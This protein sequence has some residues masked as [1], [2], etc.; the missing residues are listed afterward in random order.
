MNYNNFFAAF[1]KYVYFLFWAEIR[2]EIPFWGGA[3]KLD[4]KPVYI[5]LPIKSKVI[6]LDSK[7]IKTLIES[8]QKFKITCN[9]FYNIND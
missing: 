9:S 1:H 3:W 7:S 6:I 5:S 4:F 2:R 8:L